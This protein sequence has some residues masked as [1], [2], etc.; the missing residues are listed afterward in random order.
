MIDKHVD[1]ATVRIDCG[2]P[3]VSACRS[4]QVYFFLAPASRPTV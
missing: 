4:G 1:I 3:A 2:I